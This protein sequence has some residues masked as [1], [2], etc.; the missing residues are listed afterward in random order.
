MRWLRFTLLLLSPAVAAC[1]TTTHGPATRTVAE[2]V[3]T[4]YVMGNELH[5]EQVKESH[6]SDAEG[7]E[8]TESQVVSTEPVPGGVKGLEAELFETARDKS[9]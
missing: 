8:W 6:L 5:R 4:R 1:G 2:T 3:Q 9:N 7:R